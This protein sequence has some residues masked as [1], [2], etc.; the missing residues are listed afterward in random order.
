MICSEVIELKLQEAALKERM[1]LD[2][3]II[4]DSVEYIQDQLEKKLLEIDEAELY[5]NDG[6]LPL[7]RRQVL[8]LLAK[9]RQEEK[10]MDEYMAKYRK[11]VNEKKAL[12]SRTRTKKPIYLRGVPPHER[13]FAQG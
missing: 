5:N 10:R 1:L 3:F 9:L 12:L 8:A 13:R 6:E 2:S 4:L 7:L 11:L